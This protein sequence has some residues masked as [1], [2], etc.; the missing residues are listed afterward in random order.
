MGLGKSKILTG[1]GDLTNFFFTENGIP[2]DQGVPI[3]L[4]DAEY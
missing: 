3:S 4:N 1:F 2:V